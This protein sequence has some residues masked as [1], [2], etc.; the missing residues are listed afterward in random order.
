MSFL[1]GN[2][3][4]FRKGFETGTHNQSKNDVIV[5]WEVLES[6]LVIYIYKKE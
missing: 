4:K 2:I 5:Y 6:N 1:Y 3:K